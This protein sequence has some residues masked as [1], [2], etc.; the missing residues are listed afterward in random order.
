MSPLE[1]RAVHREL[2]RAFESRVRGQIL[3]AL[4][5]SASDSDE[6]TKTQADGALAFADAK[7]HVERA[8]GLIDLASRLPTNG[9]F[10]ADGSLDIATLTWSSIG[11]ESTLI[12]QGADIARK[13]FAKISG[14]RTLPDIQVAIL[15]PP[16]DSNARVLHHSMLI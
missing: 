16:F 14:V 7:E 6:A 11:G 9:P 1:W 10:Q 12:A 8:K 3:M 15:L 2:T 4:T 5:I 13:A